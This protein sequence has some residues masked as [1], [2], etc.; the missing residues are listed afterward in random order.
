MNP[1]RSTLA[2]RLHAQLALCGLLLMPCNAEDAPD[3]NQ[4][5]FQLN[6]GRLVFAPTTRLAMSP[7]RAYGILFG[8]VWWASP[9]VEDDAW[10]RMEEDPDGIPDDYGVRD[11]V[12]ETS[13]LAYWDLPSQAP[14]PGHRIEFQSPPFHKL[15]NSFGQSYDFEAGFRYGYPEG[16]RVPCLVLISRER[17]SG[18]TRRE[19]FQLPEVNEAILEDI[20][21]AIAIADERREPGTLL[22]RQQRISGPV[23]TAMWFDT[24]SASDKGENPSAISEFAIE[25]IDGGDPLLLQAALRTLA[26][27]PA[28]VLKEVEEEDLARVA[29]AVVADLAATESL[30]GSR[31][32]DFIGMIFDIAT[33]HSPDLAREIARVARREVSPVV[34]ALIER[35]PNFKERLDA[36]QWTAMLER[37]DRM[38]GR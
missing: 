37:I 34:R 6:Y 8:H 3:M 20:K 15:I 25:V 36:D 16:R 32:P 30:N 9:P 7:R 29:R 19:V 1:R 31:A 2:L 12:F 24:L 18:K 38:A 35:S 23:S 21:A 33:A 5:A 28:E 27:C 4:Q 22:A 10:K 13:H 11:G 14:E 26:N 17:D